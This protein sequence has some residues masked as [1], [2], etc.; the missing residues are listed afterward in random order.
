MIRKEKN[1]VPPGKEKKYKRKGNSRGVEPENGEK[2]AS[3]S[4]EL[5]GKMS[6]KEK[7]TKGRN[8]GVEK[9]IYGTRGRKGRSVFAKEGDIL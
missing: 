1:S 9:G 8:I 2:S 6:T 5:G 3:V 4:K 7:S